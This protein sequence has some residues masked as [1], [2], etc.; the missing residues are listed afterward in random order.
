MFTFWVETKKP[1]HQHKLHN[2]NYF[3]MSGV[4]VYIDNTLQLLTRLL[5]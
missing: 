3:A 5:F 2:L 1:I 4:D